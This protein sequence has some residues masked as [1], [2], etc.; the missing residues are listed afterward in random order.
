ML[1]ERAIPFPCYKNILIV[2]YKSQVFVPA[3][4]QL[5]LFPSVVCV[6]SLFFFLKQIVIFSNTH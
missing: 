1:Y 6:G 5:E 3:W 2:Y 4:I